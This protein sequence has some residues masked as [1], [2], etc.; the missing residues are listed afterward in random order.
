MGKKTVLLVDDEERLL[1]STA[2]LIEDHFHVITATNGRLALDYLEERRVDCIFLDIEMPVMNGL[3]FLQKLRDSGNYIHVII[4]TGRSCLSYAEECAALGVKGYI[5][6]PYVVE[7]I[8]KKIISLPGP[9]E[10]RIKARSRGLYHPKVREAIKFIK[11]NY[12]DPISVARVAGQ[13][14]ISSDHLTVL[15]KEDLGLS[16]IQYINCFR[17]EKAKALLKDHSLSISQIMERTGFLTEQNFYKQFK[18]CTG[19]TPQNYRSDIR[20]D[21]RP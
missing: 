4:T 10:R 11:K 13:T 15:F 17:V 18:K 21:R 5:K 1:V 12:R 6:K 9:K 19:S 3:E 16:V 2:K 14:G 8:I 20:A 7:E